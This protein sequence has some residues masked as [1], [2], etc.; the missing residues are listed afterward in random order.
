MGPVCLA[1]EWWGLSIC[2]PGA[3]TPPPGKEPVT[4][5]EAFTFGTLVGFWARDGAGTITHH[6]TRVHA[7]VL[8]RSDTP[9]TAHV[10]TVRVGAG[11]VLRI[12]RERGHAGQ[13][14]VLT[15]TY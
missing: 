11:S 13:K 8:V 10:D 14:S 2:A 5:R 4:R 1:V 12:P 3:G 9:Y 7:H 6:G 15:R